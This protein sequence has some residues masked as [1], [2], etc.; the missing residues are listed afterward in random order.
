MQKKG[1][2]VTSKEIGGLI[3]KRRSELGISQEELGATLGVTYQQVQRYE[4]GRN[5]L[6]VENIQQVAAVLSV[7]VSYFFRAG[8]PLVVA[9]RPE[10][11]LSPEESA[12][13]K[14]FKK[15]KDEKAK[16]VIVQVAKASAAKEQKR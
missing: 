7:P 14:H 15:I 4:S 2:Q 6:N 1:I 8:A 3:K 5:R 9:E 12:L 11:Y 16:N 10:P 13:L